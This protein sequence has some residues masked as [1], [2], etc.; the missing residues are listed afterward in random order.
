MP[1]GFVEWTTCT[2]GH[3]GVVKIFSEK[4]FLWVVPFGF[5]EWTTYTTGHGGD[6]KY[7]LKYYWYC[8]YCVDII[9]IF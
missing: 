7:F 8:Y 4:Y 5:V 6:A 9:T 3:G 1:S 2:T